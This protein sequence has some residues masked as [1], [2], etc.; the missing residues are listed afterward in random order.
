M[1]WIEQWRIALPHADRVLL[2]LEWVWAL[3]GEV[4]TATIANAQ[5]PWQARATTALSAKI[6]LRSTRNSPCLVWA[7]ASPTRLGVCRLPT[8]LMT[9]ELR[10]IRRLVRPYGRPASMY[11]LP[12]RLPLGRRSTWLLPPKAGDDHRDSLL[13]FHRLHRTLC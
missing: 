6:L 2:P 8:R 13:L 10:A 12:Q 1:R 3:R 5:A 11:H 9:M 4:V 7:E